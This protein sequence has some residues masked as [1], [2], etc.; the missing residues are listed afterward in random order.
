M[1][2]QTIALFVLFLLIVGASVA[3]LHQHNLHVMTV[4]A[5]EMRLQLQSSTASS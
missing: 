2:G 5:G 1:K 4:A 3:Y